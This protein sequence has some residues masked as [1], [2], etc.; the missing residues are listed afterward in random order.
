MMRGVEV[1]GMKKGGRTGVEGLMI[2]MRIEGV[3]KEKG[4]IE[5]LIE[6]M[7]GDLR[8]RGKM[9]REQEDETGIGRRVTEEGGEE[10]VGVE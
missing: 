1:E 5:M 6:E 7:I 2:R 9:I 8:R 4:M 3:C 10:G